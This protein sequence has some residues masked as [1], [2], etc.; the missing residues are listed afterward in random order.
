MNEEIVK[1]ASGDAVQKTVEVLTNIITSTSDFAITQAPMYVREY[2]TWL[3]YRDAI[4]MVLC[5]LISVAAGVIF[6]KTN[7]AAKELTKKLD[8]MRSK[9][10]GSDY[11]WADTL[12]IAKALDMGNIICI[13][14]VIVGAAFSILAVASMLDLVYTI[15]AP[16]VVI[17][18][19][20]T[21]LVK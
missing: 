21:H 12:S 20:L 9:N 1:Q 16:R 2:I 17:L 18:E 4:A 3:I 10:G 6:V 7:R 15:V 11:T 13:L 14:A 5:T 19:H 8:H